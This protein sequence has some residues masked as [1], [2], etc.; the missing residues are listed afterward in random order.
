MMDFKITVYP[1][2][3]N[4][5]FVKALKDAF[6][7][8]NIVLEFSDRTDGSI[9]EFS[10][11]HA[12]LVIT[13]NEERLHQ[14]MGLSRHDLRFVFVGKTKL[15]PEID[16]V[17]DTEDP[18]E[19]TER[20]ERLLKRHSAEFN[21]WF[22]EQ[23]LYTTIDTIPD[24]LWYKRIDGIHMMVNK[25]F[26]EIVHKKRDDV[27]GRDHFYIWDAPRPTEG[28]EFA[29]AESEEIAIRT[30]K[31]Y[32]CDE[33]VKTREGM[34]QFTTYKT[35]VYDMFGNVFGTVGVGHDV[36]NFSNLGIELSIL[37]EN[38]PFPMVIFTA[39][40]RVVKMN[41]AFAEIA[42]LSADEATDFDYE[43]WKAQTLIPANDGEQNTEKHY[44]TREYKIYNRNNE[45]A[46]TYIVT[47]QEIHDFFDNV[48]GY[49]LLMNNVTVE[50]AFEESM[51]RAANTD[52]LTGMYN[53]RYF[54]NYLS[55]NSTK[56][57][58]LFY[59]DLDR[60]KYVNDHYGHAKGDEVLVRTS[61]IIKTRFPKAVSARL[62]GDE[63][64]LVVDGI[65]SD[66][67]I[68]GYSLNLEST[69]QR[70]FTAD[71]LP[72]TMSIGITTHDGANTD[73]DELMH[74]GDQKM[75]EVKKSHH[76]EDNKS[77]HD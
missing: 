13:D 75:Y 1:E 17:W 16:D 44:T 58:T 28:N 57:M 50:R 25:A 64:A 27:I 33:P 31:C 54:Y 47:M 52:M 15:L 19:L 29:C 32:I 2:L 10:E 6:E 35:P 68:K 70:I 21:A 9:T 8:P 77:D 11:D 24:M 30:G 20:F 76:E 18:A 37:V 12:H 45:G 38:I 56:P 40:M 60:F 46:S 66:E 55:E 43:G 7:P 3:R 73:V 62:G 67:D 51:F 61:Q 23:T 63:F 41:E 42:G 71:G 49:F 26:T 72:V 14:L 69:I 5:S 74:L 22:F 34:K 4:E 39:D 59:M 53:R 48:S 65:L 36:T